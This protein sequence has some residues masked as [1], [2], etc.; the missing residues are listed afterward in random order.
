MPDADLETAV[1]AI[2]GRHFGKYRGEVVDNSD[3]TRRG[4]LLVKATA[5]MGDTELWAMPCV[6]YAGDQ[7]G[8][9]ALPP[10]GAKV[11]VEFEG[12]DTDYPIW[13]GCFWTDGQIRAGDAEPHIA[14]LRTDGV[15]IRVD[16]QAGSVEIETSGGAKI[17]MNSQ[18]IKLE[19]PQISQ[20]ANGAT[21]DL[22][23]AGFDAMGGALKVV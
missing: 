14:F 6:P 5:V 18:E 15:T 8:L 11:W 19:A 12:G 7:V 2:A 3:P 1:E 21:A 13:T 4:R 9:F 22:S 20:S 17:T 10:V 23:P 16:G